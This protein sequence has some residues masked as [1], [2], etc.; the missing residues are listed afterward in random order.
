MKKTKLI[1]ALTLA[2]EQELKSNG[3]IRLAKI[4]I[5]WN[6]S[7]FINGRVKSYFHKQ[8]I[9]EIAIK[10]FGQIEIVDGVTVD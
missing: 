1:S 8:V 7:L 3:H 2:L 10:K 4:K 5:G 9:L 6:G